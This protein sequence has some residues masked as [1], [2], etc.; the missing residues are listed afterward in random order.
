M[1]ITW[2]CTK[3][4]GFAMPAW[5]CRS[6]EVCGLTI[7]DVQI[8]NKLCDTVLSLPMHPYLKEDE[9]SKVAKTVNE[10]LG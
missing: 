10:F 7:P 3:K 6:G 9:V 8:T 2:P 1:E 4:H 5:G